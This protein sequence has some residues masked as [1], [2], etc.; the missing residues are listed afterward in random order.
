VKAPAELSDVAPAHFDQLQHGP[1][2][3]PI[4]L[5]GLPQFC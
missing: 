2:V 3:R 4:T 5:V 1:T